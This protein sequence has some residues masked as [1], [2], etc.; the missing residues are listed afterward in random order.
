V[1]YAIFCGA[2][3]TKDGINNAFARKKRKRRKGAK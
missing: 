1:E 3:G 2:N